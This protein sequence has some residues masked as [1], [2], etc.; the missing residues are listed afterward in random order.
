MGSDSS[1]QRVRS[2]IWSTVACFNA[3]SIWLT[4]NP[5][6]LHDPIAQVFAGENIDLDAFE[7]TLGPDKQT[8]AKNMARDPCAAAKFF[9]FMVRSVLQ[10]LFQVQ[11]FCIP[12]N[13]ETYHCTVD[14]CFNLWEDQKR[15]R[16]VRWH[17]CIYR[18]C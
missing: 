1:R 14:I 12:T 8:H 15:C 3:P 2:Q 13:F 10:H 18:A 6:D 16:H 9:D 5:D 7:A 4:I 11:P 17:K